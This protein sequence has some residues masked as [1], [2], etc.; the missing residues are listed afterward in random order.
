MSKVHAAD[1]PYRAEHCKAGS[2]RGCT[3]FSGPPATHMNRD[4]PLPPSGIRLGNFNPAWH[5]G[6]AQEHPSQ[7]DPVQPSEP[8]CGS[9][10]PCG[11]GRPMRFRANRPIQA[12]RCARPLREIETL[13]ARMHRDSLLPPMP[14]PRKQNCTASTAASEE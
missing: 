2:V 10:L 7:H 9:R 13:H 4:F 8:E 14:A 5:P 3:S 6:A 11:I 1:N 12:H